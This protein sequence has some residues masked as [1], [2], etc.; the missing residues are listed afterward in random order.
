MAWRAGAT[1]TGRLIVSDEAKTHTSATVVVAPRS[2]MFATNTE[3]IDALSLAAPE[4]RRQ[5]AVG[6]LALRLRRL[7]TLNRV[8]N[9]D[10]DLELREPRAPPLAEMCHQGL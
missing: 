1:G 2:S 9:R 3:T 4:A 7:T 8:A 5:N 6:S 10:A